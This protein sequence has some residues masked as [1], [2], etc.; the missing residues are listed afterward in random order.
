LSARKENGEVA[1]R[2]KDNGIGMDADLVESAFKLFR[3]GEQP[4]HRPHGGLGVGL[5][6][7][8]RLVR[9]HGGTV[10]A[11]SA[12]PNQGSEFIVRLPAAG[13]AA[14]AR[15]AAPLRPAT[16]PRRVVVV[17]DNADA[18]NALRLLLENDGH[19]V[20]VANDGVSGLALARE[21]RPDYLLLDIGL[22]R[23]SGYEIA[24][25][26][27]GDPSLKATTIV[28]I[29]GYGQVHDRIRTAAVGFDHHLTKPVEFSALQELFRT[30][31]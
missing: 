6:L 17:D 27:R 23:M 5:T 13:D 19:E 18:A 12:G 26:V 14:P 25:A 16:P 2:V 28:A 7:V 10:E 9:M 11:R 15:E 30:K 29:T 20:R 22:P 4:L 21:Y 31:A 1:I 8:D 3:Q 24:A